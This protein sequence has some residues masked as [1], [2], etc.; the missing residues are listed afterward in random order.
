MKKPYSLTI[1]NLEKGWHDKDEVLIHAAFQLLTDFMELEQPQKIIVWSRDA[2]HRKAWKE[3]MSLYRWWKKER[4]VRDKKYRKIKVPKM[5]SRKTDDNCYT[6]EPVDKVAYKKYA[7]IDRKRFKDEEK[8]FKDDQ[9]N[10][11]RL[12][13]IRQYLWT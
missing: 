13:E 7:A 9:K 1:K 6:L 2:G 3:M 4:P 11:H 5:I 8:W 10:L 12:I